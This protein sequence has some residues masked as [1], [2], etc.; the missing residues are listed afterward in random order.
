[1]AAYLPSFSALMK[2][3]LGLCAAGVILFA[4]FWTIAQNRQVSYH[5]TVMRSSLEP[6]GA[7]YS[8][9]GN[10]ADFAGFDL[11]LEIPR[12]G[13]HPHPAVQGTVT[14]W[15]HAS[16]IKPATVDIP[17]NWALSENGKTMD[18]YLIHF[19]GDRLHA[20]SFSQ[21]TLTLPP[22]IKAPNRIILDGSMIYRNRAHWDR[23]GYISIRGTA[24]K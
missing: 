14:Q 16:E 23:S 17:W 18:H 6:T 15:D 2:T 11:S 20:S 4:Y 8:I 19:S 22:D 21:I 1:M 13:S 10:L 9:P 12:L 5:L 24:P 7:S 3:Y